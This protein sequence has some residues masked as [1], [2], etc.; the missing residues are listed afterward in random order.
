MREGT[1]EIGSIF[2]CFANLGTQPWPAA[3]R[4]PWSILARSADRNADAGYI[5][6]L[7]LTSSDTPAERC[8]FHG[9]SNSALPKVCN[10][11]MYCPRAYR[12]AASSSGVRSSIAGKT[13]NYAWDG[14]PCCGGFGNPRS[15]GIGARAVENARL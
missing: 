6:R 1:G 9:A 7:P 3:I 8:W 2:R 10:F 13:A 4:L 5:R 12:M 15:D 14:S 11:L